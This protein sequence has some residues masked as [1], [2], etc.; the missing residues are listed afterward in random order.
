[1]T[2]V[3]LLVGLFIVLEDC[4]AIHLLHP[5]LSSHFFSLTSPLRRPPQLHGVWLLVWRCNEARP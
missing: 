1:M 2:R 3:L 4:Q 5:F